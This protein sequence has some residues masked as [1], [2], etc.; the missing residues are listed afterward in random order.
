LIAAG[1]TAVALG[2]A[3][4]G[5]VA[6]VVRQGGGGR[7]GDF[8]G[9]SGGY[10]TIELDGDMPEGPPPVVSFFETRPPSVR[11]LVEAVD[12]AAEDRRVKGLML[13]IGSVGTG[14]ARAQ[15]L[16]EALVRFQRSGKPSWAHLEGGGNLEYFLATGCAKIAASPTAMLDVT[17]LAAEVSFYRGTLDKLG[18]QAQFEGVGK[19]KNAPNQVTERGFTEPHREQME[20]LV[21]ALYEEYETAIAKSRRL[22]IET[23]RGL[24]DRG[25]F[26]A[27]EA[28]Q[29]GLVDELLYEDEVERRVPG[30][31]RIQP[32]P[33][34]RAARG[35][36][37]DRRP[38]LALVYA[39]GDLMPGESEQGPFGSVAGSETIIQGLRAAREDHSVRAIILRV[40]SPGGSGTASDAIWREV[41][42]AR[43]VKPVVASMGDYAASGG[44]YVAMGADEIVAQPTTI[45][46]SIGVF[47]GKLAM[48]GLYEKL[49]ISQET[50]ARG[51]NATIFSSYEPWTD[52][53]RAKIRALNQA[54]YDTFVSKAAEG[55]K[56]TEAEIEKLAQGRVWTGVEAAEG[57]LVDRLGGL[58][59]AIALARSRARIP[60]DQDVQ[61]VVLPASKGLWETLLEHQDDEVSVRFL[62]LRG[63]SL[64]RLARAISHGGPL[65]R[66][67]F[68]LAVR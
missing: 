16:R 44:F 37:F 15:E 42:L 10:L 19:Y 52:E 36:A 47:S 56:K 51:R 39:V 34:V 11:A 57:G 46:G 58:D 61:L 13:R 24:V 27:V 62:G 40:D 18:I 30:S 17:G 3:A 67:P 5:A 28:K 68:D 53:Q 45:T 6:L 32:A 22:E 50:V 8:V 60:A 20:A 65:A 12:R 14:W 2:A 31:S 66:L 7:A 21:G 49:G 26:L 38:K 54:F 63:S 1:V 55:R 23:V 48:V 25:P 64:L 41:Q 9:A 33:Y 59:A 29:V 4:V 43:R 35:G